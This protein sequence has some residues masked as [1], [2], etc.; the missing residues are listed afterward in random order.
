MKRNVKRRQDAAQQRYD[1]NAAQAESLNMIVSEQMPGVWC[2]RLN[3]GR[4]VHFYPRR[5]EWCF[6]RGFGIKGDYRRFN[7]DFMEFAEW[8]RIQDSVSEAAQ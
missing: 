5:S 2:F 3:D 8:M 1:E 7:G 6:N 4:A